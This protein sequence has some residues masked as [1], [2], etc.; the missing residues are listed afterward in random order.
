MLFTNVS[1][2]VWHVGLH[3]NT[4]CSKYLWNWRPSIFQWPF[5]WHSWQVKKP[6]ATVLSHA[7]GPLYSL[8]P[9]KFL[10]SLLWS[11]SLIVVIHCPSHCC[12]CLCKTGHLVCACAHFKWRFGA[13]LFR[14]ETLWW[15]T[16]NFEQLIS[17]QIVTWY[18][19]TRKLSVHGRTAV[20]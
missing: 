3:V 10:T 5:Q 13:K 19:C 18:A 15:K 1:M 6:T 17:R 2:I 11:Y 8:G 7:G 16:C 4:E 9:G 20:I 14:I 12:S